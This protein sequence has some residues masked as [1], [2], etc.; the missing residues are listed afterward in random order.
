VFGYGAS[1]LIVV[2]E[3]VQRRRRRRRGHKVAGVQ[4]TVRVLAFGATGWPPLLSNGIL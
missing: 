1:F 4:I 2:R 3:L